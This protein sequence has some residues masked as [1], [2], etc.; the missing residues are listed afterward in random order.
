M[1]RILTSS[2]FHSWAAC[3]EKAVPPMD[4]DF[5][6]QGGMMVRGACLE[7]SVLFCLYC[8]NLTFR[9]SG[10]FPSEAL[11]TMQSALNIALPAFHCNSHF[12]FYLL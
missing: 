8:L 10:P 11:W 6:W 4:M 12:S 9:Y 3:T 1:L 7:H 5:L 2:E